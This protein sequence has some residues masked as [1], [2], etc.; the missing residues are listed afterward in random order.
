MTIGQTIETALTERPPSTTPAKA[1]EELTNVELATKDDEQR[2]STRIHW[3]Y[4]TMVGSLL[5][6]MDRISEPARSGL[7]FASVWGGGAI[8]LTVLGLAPPPQRQK[9]R[10]LTTDLG[11][12]AIYAL[13]ASAA[14][15][16][17]SKLAEGAAVARSV[18]R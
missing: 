18:T 10:D 17:F 15:A 13:S 9:V 11:H 4:G 2:A 6:G 7:F 5:T 8:L 1:V 14:F 16:L 3:A 12:H